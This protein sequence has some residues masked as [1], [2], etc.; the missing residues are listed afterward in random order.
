MRPRLFDDLPRLERL[1]DGDE[2]HPRIRKVGAREQ[3]WAPHI[4]KQN[5]GL[6]RRRMVVRIGFDLD[7]R[8][9][10]SASI[11][12]LPAIAFSSPRSSSLREKWKMMVKSNGR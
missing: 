7:D 1:R 5:V 10:C 8:G 12:P 4:A 3:R 6:L 9:A 2:Q 11:I